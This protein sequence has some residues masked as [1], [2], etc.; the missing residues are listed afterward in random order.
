MQV[1]TS[2]EII[3][4]NVQGDI[5]PSAEGN[6]LLQVNPSKIIERGEVQITATP[7]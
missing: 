2:I 7:L 1:H 3:Y 5:L 4:P 6:L